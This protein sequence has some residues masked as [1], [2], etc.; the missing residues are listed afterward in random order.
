MPSLGCVISHCAVTLK[1]DFLSIKQ[2]IYLN[3]GTMAQKT[4]LRPFYNA[5]VFNALIK[6]GTIAKVSFIVGS[7]V[8]FFSLGAICIPL[9]GAFAGIAGAL[10]VF[11]MRM[12]IN[13][14]L[15]A[16]IPLEFLAY[17][18]PGLFAS[19]YWA[20]SNK[21]VKVLPAVL[22]MVLFLAHPVGAQAALYSLFWLIPVYLTLW[23]PKNLFNTALASTFTAHAVGSV[24]WMYT[25]SMTPDQWLML[26]PVVIAERLLFAVGMVVMY[27]VMHKALVTV[28]VIWKSVATTQA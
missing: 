13:F 5:V 14:F 27:K 21:I 8:A 25:V 28:G 3:G 18:I 26:I 12:G 16:Q 20:T 10:S 6:L 23:A 22:C 11:G 19:L 2:I 1:K 17:H 7:Q 24:I 9:S 4:L 15:T